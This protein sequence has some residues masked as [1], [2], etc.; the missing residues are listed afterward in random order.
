MDYSRGDGSEKDGSDQHTSSEK[1]G[2]DQHTIKV[3]SIFY[4]FRRYIYD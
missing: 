2:S 1:D 3:S 4:T